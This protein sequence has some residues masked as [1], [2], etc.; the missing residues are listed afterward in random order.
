MLFLAGWSIVLAQD[1]S[2]SRRKY[3]LNIKATAQLMYDSAIS[4]S[5]VEFSRG[6]LLIS[7]QCN[8]HE[9]CYIRIFTSEIRFVKIKRNAFYEGMIGGMAIGGLTGYA[10]GYVV[11][12]DDDSISPDENDENRRNSGVVGAVAGLAAGG[13]VGGITGGIVLKKKFVING[14]EENFKRLYNAL[15]KYAQLH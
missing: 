9:T 2:D 1:S 14:D 15:S 12:S 7:H 11:Y 6:S 4:G 13:L 10:A 3:S 5:I 8:V